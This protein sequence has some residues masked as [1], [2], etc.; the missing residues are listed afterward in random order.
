VTKSSTGEVSQLLKDWGGGDEDAL[1]RLIPLVYEELRR[2][3]HRQMVRERAG[4][5]LQTTAFL[6]QRKSHGKIGPIFW[7]SQPD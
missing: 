7:R 5:T 3:A 4:H 2:I 6:E 1:N